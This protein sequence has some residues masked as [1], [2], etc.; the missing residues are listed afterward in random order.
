MATTASDALLRTVREFAETVLEHGRDE[1]GD[2]SMP[3]FV[4]TFHVDSREPVP[5]PTAHR[6]RRD[7]P[8]AVPGNPATEPILR[9]QTV[10]R[11][12]RQF[13]QRK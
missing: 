9:T 11:Y 13:I 8:D 3:L 7:Y 1:Y 12:R 2:E 10:T 4:D 6:I 5:Y